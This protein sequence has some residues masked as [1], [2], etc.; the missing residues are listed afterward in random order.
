MSGDS[1]VL[2]VDDE[3]EMARAYAA[4]LRESYEVR[5][6]HDGRE[7][8][9]VVSEDVDVVLLDR[10]MPRL[11]GDEA[12]ERMRA[13]GYDARVAMVTAVDPD[14]DVVDMP[15]DTYLTKPV[16]EAEL[17]DTVETLTELAEYDEA[18]RAEFAL[19][20]KRAALEATKPATELS[21]DDRFGRLDEKLSTARCDAIDQL[22]EVDHDTVTSALSG[23][24]A[25]VDARHGA[26]SSW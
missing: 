2:V 15:F 6:A 17:S 4:W 25:N 9:A 3:V 24:S 22:G 21:D 11:S 20:E 12:L 13:R 18:V 1:T 10:R 14:F 19:A 7:A 16:R 8:L 23:L 26:V 5:T